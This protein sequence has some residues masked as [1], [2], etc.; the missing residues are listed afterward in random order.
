M[1][2]YTYRRRIGEGGKYNSFFEK[3]VPDF[4]NTPQSWEKAFA[5]LY[6]EENKFDPIKF[7]KWT[8]EY[9]VCVIRD[10][11]IEVKQPYNYRDLYEYEF[12]GKKGRAVI[13]QL[14]RQKL[15]SPTWDHEPLGRASD[16]LAA[17]YD[18]RLR[19]EGQN[20]SE[21]VR[22]SMLLQRK[23]SDFY[24]EPLDLAAQIGESRQGS[25]KA[26]G[27]GN[28][29]KERL[30]TTFV[31]E[32]ISKFPPDTPVEEIINDLQYNESD[33]IEFDSFDN[34]YFKYWQDDQRKSITIQ[35][36][37]Q[38]VSKLKKS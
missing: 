27:E 21:I 26:I 19:I 17:C 23:I 1:K 10:F 36:L 5:E 4:G 30:F 24:F 33:R 8:E 22:F 20:I 2:I 35:K 6:A 25:G 7:I 15:N 28:R 32:V 12:N 11:G 16:I 37:K 18:L 3:E 29:G 9:F 38:K 14:I 34:D 31:R 13:D